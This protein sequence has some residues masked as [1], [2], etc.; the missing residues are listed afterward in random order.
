MRALLSIQTYLCDL[1]VALLRGQYLIAKWRM[2]RVLSVID[3]LGVNELVGRGKPISVKRSDPKRNELLENVLLECMSEITLAGDALFMR[4]PGAVFQRRIAAVADA[5]TNMQSLI[6]IWV[7]E[8][9]LD[10]A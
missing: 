3:G 6:S 1:R 7:F 9:S 4:S 5:I 8:T 2:D 10:S